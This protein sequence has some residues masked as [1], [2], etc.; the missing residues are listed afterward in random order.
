MRLKTVIVIIICGCIYITL[1]CGTREPSTMRV[2]TLRCEYLEDPLGIGET[3][4]RLSWMLSAE[5]Y[6]RSQTA[7]RILV[8][9]SPENLAD[10]N[11]DLWDSGKRQ[12]DQTTQIVYD[13]KPLT[14]RIQCY[15]KVM[16]WDEAKRPTQWS[17]PAEWSIGLLERNDWE[18]E[19]I[20][21][22]SDR[23]PT[24]GT[25]R[26]EPGMPA[27]VF[28]RSFDVDSEIARATIYACSR[29]IYE[30]NVNGSRVGNDVFAPEWTDYRTRIQYRTYDVTDRIRAGWNAIGATVCDGWYSGFI[31]WQKRRGMYGLGTS[32]LVQLEIE[33]TDSTRNV[34][35]SDDIWKWSEGPI[36]SADLQMGEVYDAR[37]EIP[38][39]D[40]PDF[41]D[42]GWDTAMVVREP[43]AV[44]VPLLSQPV[45][46]TEELI[47]VEMTE[48]EPGLY[49]F[50][51][52]RNISGWVRLRVAGEAGTTV[53]M[54]H[55]E[56]L[57]PDG[58]IYTENLRLAHATDGYTLK[59]E[60]FEVFEPRFTFH[61]F[62]YVELSGFPG[63]P[64]RDTITGCVVH[65]DMPEA[66]TFT[67][68]NDMVNRLAENIT[69]GQRGNFISIPTDCPQRD[70]RLGW[71]GDAL[72]FVSTAAYNM[73]VS[74]FFTKW[75]Q[76]VVDAQASNGSFNDYV[77][78]PNPT[79]DNQQA[80]P[81][82]GDA[83]IVVPWTMYRF[84]GDT[85]IIERHW[86][87]MNDW[88]AFIEGG[89][90]DHIRRNRLGNNYG[91]WLSI[92][93]DTPK[94]MLA[95]AF[96]AQDAR[97]MVEMSEAVGRAEDAVRYQRLYNDIRTAFQE[98]YV[99]SDGRVF[100]QNG[101]LE[102]VGEYPA[103]HAYTGGIGESQT[104][105]LLALAFDLM[106][107][108]LRQ[109]AAEH[110]VRKIRDNDGHLSSGFV[111]IRHLNPVLSTIGRNDIAYQLLLTDTYPSWLY[112]IQNG[113]TTIWERWDGW[114][115][116]TGFQNPFM[117]SFN[118]YALGS[119]G[120]WLYGYVAGIRP[121]PES[122]GFKRFIIEPH[123]GNGLTQAQA[124]YRSLN[125]LIKSAWTVEANTFTLNVT[126]PPNTTATVS[127]P[128]GGDVSIG[129]PASASELVTPL[130]DVDGRKRFSVPSGSYT[131]V[132][133]DL[134]PY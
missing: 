30:L 105:Y 99:A 120:A 9:S 119:V 57:N 89:N 96:W 90:R 92:N 10:D 66:G 26:D 4:P 34:I 40:G 24:A 31:G 1:G 20:S 59:G 86:D 115:A 121:D 75:M 60:G 102:R 37:L 51:L 2:N 14:S 63:T 15:W 56:R 62:Q 134:P 83:G 11:G 73:D 108:D 94:F 35:V 76:D 3:A 18:A 13:G 28:R 81:A 128:S 131:F 87:A 80:A 41:D 82:W 61:G 95:T 129:I 27:S 58:T 84:Y 110:L 49:V 114:T 98:T 7:W 74:A 97:C 70:E 77:P 113:A 46:V 53:T 126:V 125:G 45:R 5:D 123:P 106:P 69:W 22:P 64:S 93:D 91:D 42:S 33:Y 48:P 36:R 8:A 117:N 54:R 132:G 68:S 88:M 103:S 100:P 6:A 101:D 116:E 55:A 104:G 122:P 85:R 21:G 47:P 43:S 67:C 44:I 78:N 127:V 19:W 32:L 133:T 39:W 29:G 65:S 72:T 79:D 23:T 111:G 25:G 17:E 124:T 112:P 52:G 16:S 130:G 50:D 38:G 118:H 12:E 109:S 71:M 107:E